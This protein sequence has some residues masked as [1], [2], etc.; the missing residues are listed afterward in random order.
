MLKLTDR[1]EVSS[2][3]YQLPIL[4]SAAHSHIYKLNAGQAWTGTDSGPAK[5]LLQWSV[6]P[7]S[8]EDSALFLSLLP[9]NTASHDDN[10]TS[11]I[12]SSQHPLSLSVVQP[13]SVYCCL[14]SG[15]GLSDLGDL[16]ENIFTERPSELG[17][18]REILLIVYW[19]VLHN[20]IFWS[21]WDK[22]GVQRQRRE[23]ITLC[24]QRIVQRYAM[25]WIILWWLGTVAAA[26][27]W[28]Q[29]V[30]LSVDFVASRLCCNINQLLLSIITTLLLKLLCDLTF[31]QE[32]SRNIFKFSCLHLSII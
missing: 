1:C 11:D 21:N 14:G 23:W 3:I 13:S 25:I 20:E 27:N 7:P 24:C 28:T 15:G 31:N 22:I 2:V 30:M 18:V 12:W 8:S 32:Q 4:S 26:L 17:L 9:P 10:V 29:C 16:L 19:E 5:P 6:Q